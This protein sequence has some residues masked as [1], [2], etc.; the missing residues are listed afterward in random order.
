MGE[1][2]GE[3]EVKVGEVVVRRKKEVGQREKEKEKVGRCG[4]ESVNLCERHEGQNAR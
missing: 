2:R 3:G 1:I 4:F